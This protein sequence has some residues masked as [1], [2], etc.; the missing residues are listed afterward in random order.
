MPP[1][2]LPQGKS[3][4]ANRAAAAPPGTGWPLLAQAMERAC[5]LPGRFADWLTGL[6][7]L[8]N[9]PSLAKRKDDPQLPRTVTPAVSS[10]SQVNATLG[11]LVVPCRL[12]LPP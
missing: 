2:V 12:T 3:P 10:T 11:F 1:G 8:E 5:P 9:S 4:V 6:S 7:T